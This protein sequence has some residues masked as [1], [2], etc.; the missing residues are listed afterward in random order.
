MKL[1]AKEICVILLA[2]LMAMVLVLQVPNVGAVE[3]AQEATLNFLTDVVRIDLSKYDVTLRTDTTKS[4]EDMGGLSEEA[5]GYILKNADSELSANP[6]FIDGKLNNINLYAISGSP[7]YIDK[8]TGSIIDQTR[9][10]LQRLPNYSTATYLQ[11]FATMLSSVT[12]L[13]NISMVSGNS[14]LVISIRDDFTYIRL[15]YS[16]GGIDYTRKAVVFGFTSDGSLTYF[17]DAWDLYRLGSGTVE[18]S[19]T[20]AIGIA[21]G[22]VPKN[23]AYDV[24]YRN[25]TTATITGMTVAEDTIRTELTFRSTREPLTLYPMWVVHLYFDQVYPSNFY[26]WTVYIWGDTGEVIDVQAKL[27]MGDPPGSSQS[28]TTTMDS[29][30]S[31]KESD[32][33]QIVSTTLTGEPTQQQ[34]PITPDQN[35]NNPE[36]TTATNELPLTLYIIAIV[37]AILIPIAITTIALKK[38]SK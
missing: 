31:K 24:T 9:A 36:Q 1:L 8:P 26:G 29:T 22:A 7:A 18:V 17:A 25:E 35:P 32:S 38:R 23:Y 28:S 33:S 3:S 15:L 16:A 19:E 37:S 5:I 27:F 6:I 20:D 12:E 2:S 21:L 11:Q 14:K 4:R 34:L 10:L 30:T 13:E